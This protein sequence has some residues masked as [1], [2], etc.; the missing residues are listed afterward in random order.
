MK[1]KTTQN[2]QNAPRKT[3]TTR[4]CLGNFFASCSCKAKTSRTVSKKAP[5]PPIPLTN[6]KRKLFTAGASR[7]DRKDLTQ[8]YS[9]GRIIKGNEPSKMQRM[10]SPKV[11]PTRDLNQSTERR[12]AS[13]NKKV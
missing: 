3:K 6:P 2:V 8:T 9:T 11:Y 12:A 7:I 1:F 4:S 10:S 5:V 13:K